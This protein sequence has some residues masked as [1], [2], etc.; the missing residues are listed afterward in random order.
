MPDQNSS[1]LVFL[2]FFRPSSI[3]LDDLPI[4]VIPNLERVVRLERQLVSRVQLGKK[5]VKLGDEILVCVD[6]LVYRN[7]SM[8]FYRLR[9]HT[10]HPLV[11]TDCGDPA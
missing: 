1:R 11:G 9:K 3:R 4:T 5:A 8:S 10:N 6:G 7:V 2:I